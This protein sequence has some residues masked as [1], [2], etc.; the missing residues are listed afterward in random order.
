MQPNLIHYAIPGFVLLIVIEV[1]IS[2]L[3][4]R[5]VYKPKDA[6]S[7]IAMGLGNV[8]IGLVTKGIIFT[9]Y[10]FIYQY[11]FFT[12]EMTVWW[13]WIAC[14]FA[15]D[16]SYYWFHRIS[17]TVR[18]FWASHVIHHSSQYYNLATA[19]RQTWTGNLT[20]A[21]LFWAWMPLVGF[22]P[23]MIL[24]MQSI[25][26]LYQFWIHTEVIHKLPRPVEFI[27]NTPSH[28]RVHH[29]SDLD[30]LDKNHAG[31]LIIWDRMFGTFIEEKAKPTYGITTNINTYNPLR[32][33]THEWA[34][35]FRDVR[36]AKSFKAALH[37]IFNAPGWSENGETL[38]TKQLRS[39]SNPH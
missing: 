2:S 3:Q 39:K 22:H 7:S 31:V 35:I 26:L 14:F 10:L 4:H 24:T 17:H 6:A 15:D 18:F 16:F 11:R 8:A 32:I 27:F 12:L 19:L 30:Y 25:S 28:H 5:E 9:V 33:A 23:V 34:N 20:G 1:I 29:A 36:K 37:Y 21:F 38:T 13:V